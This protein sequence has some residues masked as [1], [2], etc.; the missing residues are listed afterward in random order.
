MSWQAPFTA[1]SSRGRLDGLYTDRKLMW[2]FLVGT[3]HVD[4]AAIISI[5]GDSTW[6]STAGFTGKEGI[7]VA[8][9]TQAVLL[10]H[11]SENQQAGNATQAVQKLA[12]YLISVNY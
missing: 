1:F 7:A 10:G 8:K 5:A 6:A 11:H 3:G 12:D 4:K 9:S 2:E